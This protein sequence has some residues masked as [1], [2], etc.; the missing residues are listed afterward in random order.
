MI[1]PLARDE[2]ERDRAAK[3]RVRPDVT[4]V[5]TQVLFAPSQSSGPGR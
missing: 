1:A 2:S 5:A 4:P 3:Q